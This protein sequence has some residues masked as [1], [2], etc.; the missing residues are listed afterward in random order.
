MP[1]PQHGQQQRYAGSYDGG[2]DYNS[3]GGQQQQHEQPQHSPYEP[4]YLQPIQFMHDQLFGHGQSEGQGQGQPPN[5][6]G[7]AMLP[8]SV[9]SRARS[10]QVSFPFQEPHPSEYPPA[11]Q[12]A[13]NVP[14]PVVRHQRPQEQPGRTAYNRNFYTTL[15]GEDS[16]PPP[17]PPL[18]PPVPQSA[19]PQQQLAPEQEDADLFQT[20]FLDEFWKDDGL[21]DLGIPELE[22]TRPGAPK[23]SRERSASGAGLAQGASIYRQ[24]VASGGVTNREDDT[25]SD[26]TASLPAVDEALPQ[27]PRLLKMRKRDSAHRLDPSPPAE[28]DKVLQPTTDDEEKATNAKLW[29]LVLVLALVE[30][31][32]C[33]V[34]ND[35]RRRASLISSFSFDGDP[36]S[37]LDET[38]KPGAATSSSTSEVPGIATRARRRSSAVPAQ[39]QNQQNQQNQRLGPRRR[40]V[41][42]FL[43]ESMSDDH[44]KIVQDL[45]TWLIE[46]NA[47]TRAIH[48]S[49]G[50]VPK[51]AP[52]KVMKAAFVTVAHEQLGY[53]C[54]QH[55]VSLGQFDSLFEDQPALEF[56]K[57]A[58]ARL[59]SLQD[60]MRGF[61]VAATG[62]EDAMDSDDEWLD[63]NGDRRSIKRERLS[64]PESFNVD[65][66]NCSGTYEMDEDL[67]DAHAYM[68]EVRGV[69]W[70]LRKM[71]RYIEQRFEIIQHRYDK[72]VMQGAAKLL[73]NG[74]NVYITDGRKRKFTL[75]SPVPW[76]KPL[77]ECYKAWFT[78]MPS[79]LHIVHYY[80]DSERLERVVSYGRYRIHIALRFQKLAPSGEWRTLH[81]RAG[82]AN[83]IA[84]GEG[85]NADTFEAFP[86]QH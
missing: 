27:P 55:Q 68:R 61:S 9:T 86:L 69:P 76:S 10:R 46:E 37:F 83:L 49:L 81:E 12:S 19:P 74:T 63:E 35:T 80:S 5:P 20:Y 67:L 36:F 79:A 85:F 33:E 82:Y 70:V 40:S 58:A 45:A 73:S 77:A 71:I 38:E 22:Q 25:S 16:A 84:K 24:L 60:I 28:A 65:E 47:F 62:K 14:P 43:P 75:Q 51:S 66:Y 4:G 26:Y 17:L 64:S 52:L 30:A 7:S 56:V 29:R 78:V 15:P 21:G 41:G 54:E 57:Q 48:E 39:Q 44:R 2:Y 13:A 1:H 53:F 8:P 11:H 34:N 72:V 23:R 6:Y 50:R 31:H 3:Y 59:A 32:W 42:E 18:P